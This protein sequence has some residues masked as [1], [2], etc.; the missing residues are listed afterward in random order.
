M[1]TWHHCKVPAASTACIAPWA[2]FPGGAGGDMEALARMIEEGQELP[3][4]PAQEVRLAQGGACL[5][6]WVVLLIYLLSC[7]CC[8]VQW[9]REPEPADEFRAR[10]QGSIDYM[11][12]DLKGSKHPKQQKQR[13]KKWQEQQEAADGGQTEGEAAA[14]GGG[15]GDGGAEAQEGEAGSGEVGEELQRQIAAAEAAAEQHTS[16]TFATWRAGRMFAGRPDLAAAYARG[17]S[18][19]KRWD[20]MWESGEAEEVSG[21]SLLA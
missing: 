20:K 9:E 11:N 17:W 14:P 16:D 2:S 8:R 5:S 6:R 21:H 1:P 19:S 13:K 12:A 10:L 4:M 15:R 18:Q 7:G 3:P